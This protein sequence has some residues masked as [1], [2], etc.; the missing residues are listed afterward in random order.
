MEGLEARSRTST[1]HLPSSLPLP[2]FSHPCISLD[3]S[4]TDD[5]KKDSSSTKKEELTAEPAKKDEVKVVVPITLKQGPS[6]LPR[7]LVLP[8]LPDFSLPHSSHLHFQNCAPTW[9]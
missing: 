3:M 4:P 7:P 8:A 9:P 6:S 5:K 2:S 1:I